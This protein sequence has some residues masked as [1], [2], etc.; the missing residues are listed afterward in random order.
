MSDLNLTVRKERIV[1]TFLLILLFAT[2]YWLI[3]RTPEVIPELKIIL[4]GSII[5]TIV[6]NIIT[7]FWKI[8]IHAL[9]AFS[10]AGAVAGISIA[11]NTPIPYITYVLLAIA[12]CVGIS[13]L[14]LKRHT[15]LQVIMGGLLGFLSAYLPGYF[16]N[17]L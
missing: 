11:T 2:L 8:S 3:D 14:I 13:R 4:L 10:V 17:H 7:V 9:G 5:G 15:P 12:I 1:P 16:T 6:A